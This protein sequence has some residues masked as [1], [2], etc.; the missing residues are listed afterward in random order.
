M[1]TCPN[2]KGLDIP[3]AAIQEL[4]V[5]S[6]SLFDGEPARWWTE[7][8]ILRMKSLS[9]WMWRMCGEGQVEGSCSRGTGT[10]Q[11]NAEA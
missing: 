3:L 5:I 9:E 4:M 7:E 2:C 6:G 1:S 8:R 11:A 10:D